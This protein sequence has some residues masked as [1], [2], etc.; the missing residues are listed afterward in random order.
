M[1]DAEAKFADLE[2]LGEKAD[3][4]L[5]HPQGKGKVVDWN[6]GICLKCN[7]SFGSKKE[8]FNHVVRSKH[9]RKKRVK[10]SQDLR[11]WLK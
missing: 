5:L 10:G 4:R 7:T 1:T 6:A 8:L 11:E 3:L 9:H 2:F